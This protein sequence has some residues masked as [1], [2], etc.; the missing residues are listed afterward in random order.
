MLTDGTLAEWEQNRTDRERIWNGYGTRREWIQ[1]GYRTGMRVERQQNAFCQA[2]PVRS[3]LIGTVF[4]ALIV[5][6]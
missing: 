6:L 5:Y 3:L 1:N 2:F 4:A